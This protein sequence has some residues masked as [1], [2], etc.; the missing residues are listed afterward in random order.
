MPAS[1]A[2]KPAWNC[3]LVATIAMNRM[4][5]LLTQFIRNQV[6]KLLERKTNCQSELGHHAGQAPHPFNALSF[7][8]SL[9]RFLTGTGTGSA[10]GM[11]S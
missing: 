3:T 2:L 4:D 10:R 8:L 9:Y 1:A 5:A 11:A 6:V 7:F